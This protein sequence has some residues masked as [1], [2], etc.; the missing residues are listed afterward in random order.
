MKFK[1]MVENFTEIFE[2]STAYGVPKIFRSKRSILKIFWSIFFVIF[3]AASIYFVYDSITDYLEYDVITQVQNIY[4]HPM[5]FPTVSLCPK[6][7]NSWDNRAV[8]QLFRNLKFNNIKL[9]AKFFFEKFNTFRGDCFRFNSGKNI[10][11]HSVSILNSTIG[12]RDDGLYFLLNSTDTLWVFVHEPF[13]PPKF[14]Y[15]FNYIGNTNFAAENATTYL[16]IHKTVETKPGLPYN[17]C[18]NDVNTFPLNKTIINYIQSLDQTYKQMKCIGLCFDVHFIND[19]PCNCTDTSIGNVYTDCWY[20][21]QNKSK[22]DCTYQFKTEFFRQPILEKC[23]E[24]C[25]LECDSV[26][27]SVNV[28]SYLNEMNKTEVYLYYESLIYTSISEIPKTKPFDL[29]S[30]IGGILGLFV[31]FS[32]MSLFEIGELFI[33][34]VCILLNE[35]NPQINSIKE[36]K[37]RLNNLEIEFKE[38]KETY[39]KST[40]SIQLILDLN[41]LESFKS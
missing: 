32:F 41:E 38:L 26:S 20:K 3:N 23:K 39:S 12:G 8:K 24:Y 15:Q 27:Y 17:P 28:E 2:S 33:E 14:E 5:P 10:S 19:N 22:S 29:I 9:N 13:S 6:D 40:K 35:K 7:V 34:G 16:T 21:L 11:N 4:Q 37:A 18:Y 36:M 30:N 25:P 1:L 31:G